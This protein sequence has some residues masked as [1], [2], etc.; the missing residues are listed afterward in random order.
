[1]SWRSQ[2]NI[3]M[4]RRLMISV[5]IFLA[6]WY[7][8]FAAPLPFVVTWWQAGES[9]WSDT[10][11]RRH[12]M[13]DTFLLSNRLIGM[14]HEEVT[15]LLGK[16]PTTDYFRDWSIVYRLGAERGFLS[17]DSEWLAMRTDSRGVVVDAKIVRD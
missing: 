17:I 1:M 14:T 15:D 13:A 10:Y 12:R 6:V 3:R 9:N 11:K 7:E 4:A 2:L 8:L 16:Q 5:V